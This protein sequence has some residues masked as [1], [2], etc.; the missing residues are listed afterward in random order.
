MPL[1]LTLIRDGADD[2]EDDAEPCPPGG[3]IV[4]LDLS[5]MRPCLGPWRA[6]TA[7]ELAEIERE[8]A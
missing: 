5:G 2:P 3:C 7:A 1:T 4:T 8:I 6:A